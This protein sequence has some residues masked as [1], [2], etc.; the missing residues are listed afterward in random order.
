MQRI[1]RAPVLSATSRRVS[2]WITW[3]APGLRRGASASCATADGVSIDADDVALVGVV[4]LVVG[5]QRRRRAHDLLV[6]AVPAGGVDADGDRLVG[7]GGDDGARGAPCGRPSVPARRSG[8]RP[9]R[10]RRRRLAPSPRSAAAATAAAAFALRAQARSAALLGVRAG[11][12]GAL[13]VR[14]LARARL[15]GARLAAGAWTGSAARARRQRPRRQPRRSAAVRVGLGGRRSPRRPRASGVSSG[16]SAVSSSSAIRSSRCRCRAGGRRSAPARGRASAPRRPAVFSSSPVACWKRRPKSSRRAVVDVL[17]A[18]SCRR[19]R[20][21][22][23]RSSL[24]TVLS[25]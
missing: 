16:S 18:S 6:P 22:R 13:D 2:F 1:S 11:G 21:V 10:A 19:A 4:G 15:R 9:G 14:A 23:W 7:L 24:L 8:S 25:Q 20:A 12:L 3:H 17:R 5:V